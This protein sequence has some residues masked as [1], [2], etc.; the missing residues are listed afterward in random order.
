MF[1]G[2]AIILKVGKQRTMFAREIFF[3]VTI[4]KIHPRGP[5]YL[6]RSLHLYD[7]YYLHGTY[8]FRV[9]LTPIKGLSLPYTAISPHEAALRSGEFGG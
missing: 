5:L 3:T 4:L 7:P 2:G 1:N 6:C 9:A 8:C